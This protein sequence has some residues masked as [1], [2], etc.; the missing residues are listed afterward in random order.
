MLRR[1]GTN[2][3]VHQGI[4]DGKIYAKTTFHDDY[5]LAINNKIRMSGML[6]KHKLGLHE[7]EDTRAIISCP[8]TMQW[9]LFKKKHR[10]TY[11]LITANTEV[12]R[13]KGVRQI[14]LLHPDW[15]LMVRA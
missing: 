9:G 7:N 14:Q 11:D 2:A 12:E 5:S 1:L 8:S 4:E 13:M 15:V 10:E 3:V 6:D